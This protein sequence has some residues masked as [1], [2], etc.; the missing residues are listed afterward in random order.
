M[1]LR[2]ASRG[3]MMMQELPES[4]QE[5]LDPARTPTAATPRKGMDG[6]AMPNPEDVDLMQLLKLLWE[7]RVEREQ[8]KEQL[9]GYF[10]NVISVWEQKGAEWEKRDTQNCRDLEAAQE[11]IGLLGKQNQELLDANEKCRTQDTA[12]ET[13]MAQMDA[14]LAIAS[15]NSQLL[16]QKLADAGGEKVRACLSRVRRCKCAPARVM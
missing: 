7:S 5:N 4:S 11:A 16:R 10:E 13:E 9:S 14:A 15:S 2:D 6:I 8:E 1:L 3:S 12:L